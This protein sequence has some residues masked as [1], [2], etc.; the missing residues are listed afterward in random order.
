[1]DRNKS[2]IKI[3]EGEYKD[4]GC[5][6]NFAT[7]FELLIA[8]MLSAQTT[9][10]TVNKA[11]EKLFKEFNKPE[12]FEK[13]N[14]EQL[15]P[16]IKSCGFYKTKAK[17]IIETSKILVRDFNSKV[18]KSL[19]ELITLPGVGRKTANVVLSNAFGMDAIAVDTHVFRVSNRIGLADANDVDETERQLMNNIPKEYWSRAHHWLIWH[20]RKICA[21]RKPKCDICPVS[22]LCKHNNKLQN[23]K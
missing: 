11:T 2:I 12:D 20:G 13:L 23:N 19:E 3:L 21:A 17:N 4:M 22:D 1:M 10:I 15:E 7:P 6:L 8:T 16:Y 14:F 9:D 18:P 5:A